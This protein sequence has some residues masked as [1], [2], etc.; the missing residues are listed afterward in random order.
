[1]QSSPLKMQNKGISGGKAQQAGRNRQGATG[2][3]K[4]VQIVKW[5]ENRRGV[6]AGKKPFY[7]LLGGFYKKASRGLNG[8]DY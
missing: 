5:R 6:I 4:F 3:A 2:G 1:M 7:M 8:H